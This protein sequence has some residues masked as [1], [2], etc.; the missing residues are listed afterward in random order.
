MTLWL[1]IFLVIKRT[2]NIQIR[3]VL[4]KTFHKQVAMD[5]KEPPTKT[6]QILNHITSNSDAN[7]PDSSTPGSSDSHITMIKATKTAARATETKT[8]GTTKAVTTGA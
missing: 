8:K 4:R 6:G 2:T 7:N 3:I 5:L 1:I